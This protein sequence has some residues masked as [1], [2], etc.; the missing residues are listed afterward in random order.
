MIEYLGG[1]LPLSL[2]LPQRRTR[3][4]FTLHVLLPIDD[5]HV[6]FLAFEDA[7]DVWQAVER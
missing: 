7:L 3:A 5:H 4:P 6:N 1:I 2:G